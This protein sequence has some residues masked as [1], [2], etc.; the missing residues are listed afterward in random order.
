MPVNRPHP[1]LPASRFVK[2]A[3]HIAGRTLLP[4]CAFVAAVALAQS[5][6]DPARGAAKAAACTACHGSAKA[7]ALPGMPYLDA[8][9]PQFLVLQ[10]FFIREGLRDVPQMRG[11][12]NGFTDA[13]LNEVA[14]YFASLPPAQP[15]GKADA[16]LRAQGEAL[17]KSMGC[18]SCHMPGFEGQQQMPRITNQR[19]DYL[20]Q[21]L[22]AYRDNKRSGSDTQMNAVMYRVSDSDISALAHFLAHRR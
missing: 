12:L 13:D 19:E 5:Q 17:A 6:I 8:Q 9:Q 15:T 16:S 22:K 21:T 18:G 10:M 14:A 1:D 3:M 4:A 20:V 7:P 2:R 11:M